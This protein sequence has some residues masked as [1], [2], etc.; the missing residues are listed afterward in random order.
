MIYA[1]DNPLC[2]ELLTSYTGYSLVTNMR[3]EADKCKFYSTWYS[4]RFSDRPTLETVVVKG[5]KTGYT[6]EAGVCLVTYAESKTTGK[7]YV[8]VIV[9]KPKGSGLSETKSTN[10]VKM[11]YNKYAE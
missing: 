8:N 6:D 3:T 10:E 11:I 1:L 9:G 5:G 7:K 2:N 4:G